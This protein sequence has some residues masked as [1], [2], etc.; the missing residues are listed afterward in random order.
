MIKQGLCK[1]TRF[2]LLF[3][4]HIRIEP[5]PNICLTLAISVGMVTNSYCCGGVRNWSDARIVTT[6][7]NIADI[8]LQRAR[9][10]NEWI[11]V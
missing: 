6:W 11:V 5:S 3:I 9:Q 7:F 1:Q 10:I 8:G 4:A 2:T